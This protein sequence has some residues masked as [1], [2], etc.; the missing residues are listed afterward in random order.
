MKLKSVEN[1]PN[2]IMLTQR[3][4]VFRTQAFQN[5]WF[6]VQDLSSQLVASAL[7]VKEGMR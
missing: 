6:E 5:G 4:N 7:A 2:A 1:Y 3:K